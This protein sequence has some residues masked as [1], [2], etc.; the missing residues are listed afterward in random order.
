MAGQKSCY[1]CKFARE[2]RDHFRLGEQVRCQWA[3]EQFG[4]ERWVNVIK[5]EKTGKVLNSKCGQ[6]VHVKEEN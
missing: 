6:F 5:S 3:E 4:G 2:A 1:A